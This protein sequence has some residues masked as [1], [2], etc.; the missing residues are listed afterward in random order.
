M[1]DRDQLMPV[2]VRKHAQSIYRALC[3]PCGARRGA[4][5]ALP[6]LNDESS[7]MQRPRHAGT[8]GLGRWSGGQVRYGRDRDID[9]HSLFR[10]GHQKSAAD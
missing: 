9:P 6:G 10:I 3:T 4:P 8:L 1:Q 5:V 7:Q 2:K